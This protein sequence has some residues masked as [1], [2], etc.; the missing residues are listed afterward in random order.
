M[1]WAVLVLLTGA[2]AMAGCGRGA[3]SDGGLTIDASVA[4]IRDIVARVA[5]RA[6]VV[7]L[8]PDG[9]DSH[10]F[11]PSPRTAKALRDADVVF[12]NGLHLEDPTLRLAKADHKPGSLIVELGDRTIGPSEYQFD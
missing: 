3:Q 8:V 7:Q 5:G 9:V 11:E 6:R 10:T 1:R 2:V 4:P 12:L